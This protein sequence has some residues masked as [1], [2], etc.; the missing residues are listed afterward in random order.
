MQCSFCGTLTDRGVQARQAR[1]VQNDAARHAAEQRAAA[2]QVRAR[3]VAQQSV[4]AAGRWAL[5]SSLLGGLLCCFVPVGSVLGIVFGMR[6][7]GLA[8][9]HR[10][11]GAGLGTVGLVFGVI[12]LSL[13][14][15]MWIAV[16]VMMVKE[17][18]HRA[19]LKASLGDL[20]SPQLELESACTLAELELLDNKFGGYTSLDDFECGGPTGE[21]ELN[22]DEAVL[23][24]VHFLKTDQRVPV[25]ACFVRHAR[26]SVKEVRGDDD[27]HAPKEAKPHKAKHE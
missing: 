2:D 13:S 19:E 14:I 1:A 5:Y 4:D 3:V 26:W 16:G 15:V 24:G 27:C 18:Q 11:P 7:R 10:L 22:G 8:A 25:V 9:Q 23:R 12:G 6:A 20:S 21:L 17:N